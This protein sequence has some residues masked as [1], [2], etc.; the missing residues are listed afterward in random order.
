MKRFAIILLC[1]FATLLSFSQN[2]DKSIYSGGMLF[3]QPGYIITENPH[4]DITDFSLGIGGI[5]RLYFGNY[6]TTGI[7]GG[8]QKGGYTSLNSDQ[9]YISLGYGGPFIGFSRK[10]GKFRFTASAFAGMGSVKNLHI[11]NQTG[12][13]LDDAWLYKHPALVVSPI[14]SVDYAITER[15][16]ATVQTICLAAFYDKNRILISPV[17]QIGILF[18]R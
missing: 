18:S 1:N 4:Q 6:F 16:N 14:V 13:S 12:N 8:T 5:L 17:F 3:L 15:I 7:Y 10:S 2:S 11:E 9:S